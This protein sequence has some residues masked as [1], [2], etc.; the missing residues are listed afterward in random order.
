MK[1]KLCLIFAV[2]GSCFM[3]AQDLEGSWRWTSPDGSKQFEIQ[4]EQINE[5][6]Y[7]GKHCAVFDNGEQID[8]KSESDT[9]SIVMLEITDG[10]FA[11]TIES[12]YQRSQGKIKMQ[13]HTQQDLLHFNLTK[14]PEGVFYLP[15]EAILTR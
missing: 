6:E 14:N 5:K 8:C 9:F 10:N 15:T 11:G 4:L 12:S 13:Y 1:L 7:R 3:S 2:F